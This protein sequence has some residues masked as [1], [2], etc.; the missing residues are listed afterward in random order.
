VV[1][2]AER[3]AV[4]ARAERLAVADR[5]RTALLA[6]VSH[7]LR[8]ALASAKAAVAGLRSADVHFGAEDRA[9]LSA[10]ADESL[11]RLIRLVV[12]LLDMS[13]RCPA[14]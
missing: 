13:W 3:L 7:D 9:E 14:A 1:V 10:T 12:N 11:D 2:R 6:A 4:V 5:M 8:T